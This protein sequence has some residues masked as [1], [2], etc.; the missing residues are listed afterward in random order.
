MGAP[1]RIPKAEWLAPPKHRLAPNCAIA[2]ETQFLSPDSV[3]V[4]IDGRPIELT[5]ESGSLLGPGFSFTEYLL[6]RPAS[7]SWPAS[8]TLHLRASSDSE[9]LLS[10]EIQTSQAALAEV[11][12]APRFGKPALET[13][14]VYSGEVYERT[15]LRIPHE[16]FDAT[17]GAVAR[18]S[19]ELLDRES[20]DTLVASGMVTTGKAGSILVESESLRCIAGGELVDLAGGRVVIAPA[21]DC[22]Q[23]S[24]SKG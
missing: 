21:H 13:G 12:R 24:P 17:A 6:V 16:A 15:L 7:G 18:L 23:P 11:P 5:S 4:E 2:L 9:A 3:A 14:P 20:G 1:L 19:L 8:K 10:V 22:A